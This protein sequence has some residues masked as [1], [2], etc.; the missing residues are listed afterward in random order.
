MLIF[1]P[2]LEGVSMKLSVRV[3]GGNAGLAAADSG[4]RTGLTF[5]A[6]LGAGLAGS[7]TGGDP[8]DMAI[9][10]FV[11]SFNAGDEASLKVLL[12][13]GSMGGAE[14]LD[15][16]GVLV[17]LGA[18]GPSPGSATPALP[19]NFRSPS[20]IGA[21]C[22]GGTCDCLAGRAGFGVNVGLLEAAID[23]TGTCCVEGVAM[24]DLAGSCGGAG[25]GWGGGAYHAGGN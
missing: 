24:G 7:C 18:I 6:S 2:G 4:E 19:P 17:G 21:S 10:R 23:R 1:D 3:R 20:S 25:C 15:V 13:F 9:D 22:I 11:L 8:D 12:L 5:W 14:A 16:S